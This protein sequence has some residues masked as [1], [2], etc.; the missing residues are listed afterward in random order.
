MLGLVKG[1]IG[2]NLDPNHSDV[3]QTPDDIKQ[4]QKKSDSIKNKSKTSKSNVKKSSV[5]KSK[6]IERE[7]KLNL[8]YEKC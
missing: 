2:I 8:K 4:K 7:P 6:K 1:Y 3:I 5:F